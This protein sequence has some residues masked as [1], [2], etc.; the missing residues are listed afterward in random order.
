MY[1]KLRKEN[2]AAGNLFSS[3]FTKKKGGGHLF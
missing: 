1:G 2:Y 3:D